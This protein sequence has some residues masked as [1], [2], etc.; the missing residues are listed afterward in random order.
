M[1]LSDEQ[2]ESVQEALIALEGMHDVAIVQA[3]R[4]DGSQ[5]P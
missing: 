3:E 5:Q 1:A 2:A 4:E